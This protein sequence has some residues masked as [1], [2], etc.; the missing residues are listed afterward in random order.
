MPKFDYL[1][2]KEVR[3]AAKQE[4]AQLDKK[5]EVCEKHLGVKIQRMHQVFKH[6]PEK[7]HNGMGLL[8]KFL[9]HCGHNIADEMFA[10]VEFD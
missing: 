3:N 9:Q 4:W 1:T 8:I 5:Q 10:R 2:P 7:P 6:D